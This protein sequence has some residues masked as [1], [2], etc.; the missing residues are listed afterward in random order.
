LTICRAV[1]RA[2]GGRVQIRARP[3]GGTIVE[4]V[5][6]AGE[7]ERYGLAAPVRDKEIHA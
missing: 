3:G 6:P 7:P 5:L 2:H 4:F 1:A